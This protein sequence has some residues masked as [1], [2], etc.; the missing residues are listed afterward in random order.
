LA[1]R[2]RQALRDPRQ[3]ETF[4][5]DAQAEGELAAA[6]IERELDEL[7][8]QLKQV[9]PLRTLGALHVFDAM[10]GDGMPGPANFGSDAMLDLLATVICSE[11]ETAVLQRIEEQ[12][13]PGRL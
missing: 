3:L 7:R 13:E 1:R 8:A 10:R 5:K 11:D 6:A 4:G 2:F 12:F 9:D